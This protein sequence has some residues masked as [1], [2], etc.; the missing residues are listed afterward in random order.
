M[1][2]GG[3]GIWVISNEIHQKERYLTIPARTNYVVVETIEGKT[4]VNY[5]RI[6]NGQVVEGFGNQEFESDLQEVIINHLIKLHPGYKG[7]D[8][9]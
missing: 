6:K 8:L 9:S 1:A 5:Q 7:D 4:C 3:F 2:L